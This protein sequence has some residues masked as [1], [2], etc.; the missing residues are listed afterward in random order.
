MAERKDTP[1]FSL[2]MLAWF[3]QCLFPD[4]FRKD[5]IRHGLN[6]IEAQIFSQ[7]TCVKVG[8]VATYRCFINEERMRNILDKLVLEHAVKY[9]EIKARAN[10]MNLDRSEMH[11]GR[12]RD[13]TKI[14]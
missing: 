10:V 6:E 5:L 2:E 8:I 9:E 3:D 12:F 7:Y 11:T 14:P 1:A 4:D 13:G